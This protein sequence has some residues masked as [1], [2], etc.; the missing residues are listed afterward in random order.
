MAW[1]LTPWGYE[2][3]GALPTLLTV[4]E[5]NSLTNGELAA[6]ARV[7]SAI[8]ATTSAIRKACGW[9]VVGSLPCRATLDGGGCKLLLPSNR[10]TTVTHVDVCGC[11]VTA[12]EWNRQGFVRIPHSPDVLGAVVVEYVAGYDDAPDDLKDLIVQHVT[13]ALTKSAGVTQETAG[14]V[15]I[16]YAQGFAMASG[17]AQLSRAEHDALAS[18]RLVEA[19]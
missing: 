9:H 10:V 14:S 6:D 18:Y 1:T 2:V 3:D 13:T 17:G 5:F 15:S 12:Y 7:E 4:E 19:V 16:S 8:A 11:E